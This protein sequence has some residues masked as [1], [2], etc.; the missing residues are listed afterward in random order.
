MSRKINETLLELI[1]GIL[2]S[3]AVVQLIVLLV[4]GFLPQF[5]L[6]FWI[7]IATAVGLSVHMYWSIDRALD[8]YPK[9]AEKY[10]RKAYM[11][12]TV[13]ILAVAGV[14]TYFRLGYVMATFVGV[15]CLKFGAF[16][17][18]LTH[19]LLIRA[20]LVAPQEAADGSAEEVSGQEAAA[21]SRIDTSDTDTGEQAAEKIVSGEKRGSSG[22]DA[23]G[24]E[25]ESAAER[26]EKPVG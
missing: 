26:E 12:R 2:F 8:M 4:A 22:T 20:G 15:L 21:E 24:N 18:P 1:I 9:D 3:G 13:A 14:V 10:M 19:R 11:I 7:G 23:A 17:Q 6:G 25:E 5:A 16:L